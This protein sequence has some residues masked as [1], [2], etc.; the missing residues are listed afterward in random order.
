M[1]KILSLDGGGSKGVY[2]IGVLEEL[3][4][5]LG[6][7]LYNHFD[8]VYGT[9]TGSIIGALIALGE[10]ISKVKEYYFK[11]IPDIMGRW[12]A[13]TRSKSLTAHSL[14]IFGEKE[15]DAF[16]IDI[17]I[18]A[19][20]YDKQK[21]L[22]FKSDV[23]L[24]HG[25]KGSFRAGFGVKIKDAVL[26][27]CAA[28]PIFDK[29]K[30]NISNQG[31]VT[32]IDGGFV[33]NNPTLFAITDANKAIEKDTSTVKVLSIG[34]G[35]Y[36]EKPISLK[37]RFLNNFQITQLVATVLT[38]SSVTNNQLSRLLFSDTEIIRINDS[39][40]EKKYETNMV[41]KETKK[42]EAMYYLGRTSFADA[43]KIFERVFLK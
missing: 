14:E 12:F 13:S 28:Y 3:E 37:M 11:L 36:Q 21:P 9:S 1:Y 32:V 39:F 23:K 18:V 42:L 15:F 16:K 19:T 34:V 38:T 20:N 30:L 26:A 17:G 41:E 25:Q 10:P 22:I 5:K 8:L 35:L 6:T 31:I 7:E 33:A 29:V 40:L 4:Q 24:A 43:E 27:S 2:T